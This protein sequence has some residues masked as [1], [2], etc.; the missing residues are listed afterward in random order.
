[1]RLV[2][3]VFGT[4]STC[5]GCGAELRERQRRPCPRCGDTRRIH[6]RFTNER[7]GARDKAA[8]RKS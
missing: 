8:A 5:T 3:R 7:L 2:D 1:M 6:S 4:F